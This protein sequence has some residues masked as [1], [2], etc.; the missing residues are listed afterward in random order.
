MP[1]SEE[2]HI[3][4]NKFNSLDPTVAHFCA[5]Y[6]TSKGINCMHEVQS[7]KF[8]QCRISYLVHLVFVLTQIQLT[9]HVWLLTLKH[10]TIIMVEIIH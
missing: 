2:Y 5:I 4:T 9:I 10:N 1:L 8:C 6:F 3:N 7:C